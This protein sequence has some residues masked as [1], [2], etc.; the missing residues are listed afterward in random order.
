[1]QLRLLKGQADSFFFNWFCYC[2]NFYTIY[3]EGVSEVPLMF[4]DIFASK[5]LIFTSLVPAYGP[6]VYMII[7]IV[8]GKSDIGYAVN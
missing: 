6:G 2:F 1:M 5:A 8:N 4:Y 3:C 7:N